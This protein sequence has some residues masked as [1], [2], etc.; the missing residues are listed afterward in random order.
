MFVRIKSKDRRIDGHVIDRV[1]ING[2]TIATISPA[3]VSVKDKLPEEKTNPL[4]LDYEEV[5]CAVN[6]SIGRDVR[7]YKFGEG[8]FWHGPEIMDQYITHWMPKPELPREE[9]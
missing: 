1:M 3:W 8:H 7:V 2:E 6:F 9:T 5:V 4:T